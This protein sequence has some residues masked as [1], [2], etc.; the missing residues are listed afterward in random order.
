MSV[1]NE[2]SKPEVNLGQEIDE[3]KNAYWNK[4]FK[5]VVS[6]T[7]NK[8][9]IPKQFKTAFCNVSLYNDQA[10]RG[11]IMKGMKLNCYND[12][13]YTI[14][15]TYKIKNKDIGK[16]MIY[17][18][19]YSIDK[20]YIPDYLDE[21]RYKNAPELT[22]TNNGYVHRFFNISPSLLSMDGEYRYKFLTFESLRRFTEKHK[23]IFND[24]EE[25]VL[26]KLNSNSWEPVIEYYYPTDKYNEKGLEAFEVSVEM[27]RLQVN[28]FICSYYCELFKQ[29]YS[30]TEN[31]INPKYQEVIFDNLGEDVKFFSDME[32]KY[33]YDKLKDALE[34]LSRTYIDKSPQQ[35][36]KMG[37]KLIPLNL[38][39]VEE[40][41]DISHKPWKEILISN[42]LNTFYCNLQIYQCPLYNDWFYIKNCRKGLFDNEVQY[43]RMDNSEKARVIGYRLVEAQD[44]TLVNIAED[45]EHDKELD[46]EL[47]KTGEIE[48]E[49]VSDK[50]KKLYKK[51]DELLKFSKEEIVMSN[52]CLG[53]TTE[54]AGYTFSDAVNLNQRSEEYRKFSLDWTNNRDLFHKLVFDVIYGL[55]V[56]HIDV[57]MM[58]GDLHLN[59]C[60]I[61]KYLLHPLRGKVMD[62]LYVL[63]RVGELKNIH[64]DMN[65]KSGSISN[66]DESHVYAFKM[67]YFGITGSIIDY[68]RAIILPDRVNQFENEMHRFFKTDDYM[69]DLKL[70]HDPKELQRDQIVR[71]INYY[72]NNFNNITAEDKEKLLVMATHNFDECFKLF[73]ILDVYSF[74][75]K[76]RIV[77]SQPGIKVHNDNVILLNSIVNFA[78][79]YLKKHVNHFLERPKEIVHMRESDF[80]IVELMRKCFD[81]NLVVDHTKIGVVGNV[82]FCGMGVGKYGSDK[83]DE[84]PEY[85][86]HNR[87]LHRDGL[88]V[89]YNFVARTIEDLRKPPRTNPMEFWAKKL[90]G[91]RLKRSTLIK[92][93]ADRHYRKNF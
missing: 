7:V 28:L 59:N 61:F 9:T 56:F 93:I 26:P 51:I 86:K 89:D 31:H 57:G 76:L 39:E 40:P 25:H 49:Y 71:L 80:P 66:S 42:R 10:H 44:K 27:S 78:E 17:A 22:I 32:T 60:T 11:A 72:E 73:S 37:Q 54:Y 34:I 55:S 19:C 24:V 77:L 50:F 6:E 43:K 41:L 82:V 79:F 36:C 83:F 58:H 3:L 13:M 14:T 23:D 20:E 81:E 63:N 2:E 4:Y 46:I 30:I 48:K 8:L 75:N 67:P 47:N 12:F 64:P 70:V 84:Y 85:M 62:N 5:K 35:L 74:C 33:G 21:Y 15:S 88:E 65:I 69:K 29:F 18:F 38:W 16:S 68:S 1:N 90:E 45:K 52:V 87:L 53:Y 92:Y 91:T